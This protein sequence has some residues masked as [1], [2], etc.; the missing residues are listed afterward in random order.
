MTRINE[1]IQRRKI[2]R[3]TEDWIVDIIVYA[4]ALFI[5]CVTFYPFYLAIILAFNEGTDA[6]RGGIYFWPRAFTLENFS[7][8]LVDPRW[9]TALRITAMRTALGTCITTFFTCFVAYGLSDRELVGRKLYMSLIIFAMYFSGGI[10]PYYAL[11][12]SLGL[13]NTFWVYIFPGA[14]SIF[15]LLV[16]ISFFQS[17]PKELAESARIDGAGEVS[18][19]IK[20]ILP[21]SKPLLATIAIFTAVGHWNAWFDSAFFIFDRGLRTLGY[22]LMAIIN[23]QLAFMTGNLP[24]EAAAMATV[25]AMSVQLAAMIVAVTPILIV[26][27]FFQRYFV[28][29]LSLGAVKG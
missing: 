28:S 17:I 21:I 19:F 12:R 22:Q 27:P 16:S 29:G 23:Q 3:T 7:M 15:Y 2:R 26:Y 20:I 4:G 11:L 25:T 10:I 9:L 1:S 14:L 8:F 5:F 24:P 18:I 13:I 6:T